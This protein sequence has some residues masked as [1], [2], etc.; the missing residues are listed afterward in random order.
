M[1]REILLVFQFSFLFF[2]LHDAI[3]EWIFRDA[4]FKFGLYM[5]FFEF[6]G[7]F[8]G[9]AVSNFRKQS[10]G[11]PLWKYFVMSMLVLI[12]FAL[13]NSSLRFVSY[14][15]KVVVKSCKLVPAMALGTLINGKKYDAIAY[16][17]AI[18]LSFAAAGFAIGDIETSDSSHT[19]GILMLLGAISCD[20]LVP[21]IQ[22]KVFTASGVSVPVTEMMMWTN[23]IGCINFLAISGMDG[24][25][26]EALRHTFRN[27]SV[28]VKLSILGC[29][30]YF[31]V[32]VYM[33][34]IKR[35]SGPVGVVVTT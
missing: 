23:G 27:P 30:S 13:G 16:A 32:F 26:R 11:V 29:S 10:S 35:H 15:T 21:N 17:S 31:G 33:K 1:G 5:S 6:L 25:L 28:F 24:E 3:Q 22:E 2:A 12:S 18:C 7:C 4:T 20:V 34:L 8:V 19:I 14:P 9:S